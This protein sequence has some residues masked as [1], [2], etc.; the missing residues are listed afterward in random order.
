MTL[1]E[2]SATPEVLPAPVAEPESHAERPRLHL[3]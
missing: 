2:L 3:L 1:A